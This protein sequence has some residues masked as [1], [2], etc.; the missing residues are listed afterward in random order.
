MNT[1]PICDAE[2][3]ELDIAGD[4]KGFDR[5]RQGKFLSWEAMPS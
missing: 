2:T 5:P 4:A 1:C 3:V